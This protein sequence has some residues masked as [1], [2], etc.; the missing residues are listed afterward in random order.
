MSWRSRALKNKV[1]AEL[2]YYLVDEEE[3]ELKELGKGEL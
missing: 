1:L 3:V 2:K